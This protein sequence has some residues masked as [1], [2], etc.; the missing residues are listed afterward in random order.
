[1]IRGDMPAFPRT[2]TT[3]SCKGWHDPH[4]GAT[5]ARSGYF[6]HP[7]DQQANLYRLDRVIPAAICKGLVLIILALVS[8]QWYHHIYGICL[9]GAYVVDASFAAV[10]IRLDHRIF[11]FDAALSCFGVIYCQI[12]LSRVEQQGLVRFFRYRRGAVDGRRHSFQHSH[13]RY[14]EDSILLH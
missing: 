11:T 3:T 10:H 13:V 9:R 14:A 1:M 8:L 4:A 7:V 6:P 12:R 2:P 5:S